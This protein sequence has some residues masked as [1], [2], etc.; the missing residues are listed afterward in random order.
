MYFMPESL[1]V[2]IE[3]KTNKDILGL[4]L[5]YLNDIGRKAKASKIKAGDSVNLVIETKNVSKTNK[6]ILKT[7]EGMA[8]I[9]DCNIL[10]NN[11]NLYLKIYLNKI[12][13][14][15]IEFEAEYLKFENAIA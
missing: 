5:K 15:E 10:E 2:I 9:V 12:F 11:C 3:N 8:Y 1:N 14:G 6:F 13:D 4:E 7:R